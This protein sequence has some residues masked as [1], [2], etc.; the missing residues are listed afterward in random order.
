MEL[1][2]AWDFSVC[3]IHIGYGKADLLNHSPLYEVV[4]LCNFLHLCLSELAVTLVSDF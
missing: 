4:L 3:K 1:L 2:H